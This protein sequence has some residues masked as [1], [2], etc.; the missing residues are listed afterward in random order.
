LRGDGW[1]LIG[2]FEAFLDLL[3]CGTIF[4]L[5]SPPQHWSHYP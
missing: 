4:L 5:P 3:M 2:A 1:W